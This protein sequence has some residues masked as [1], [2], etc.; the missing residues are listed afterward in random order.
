LIKIAGVSTL[1]EAKQYVDS[2]ATDAKVN[3]LMP[4][5]G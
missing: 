1:E 4:T 5:I 3:S 2:H